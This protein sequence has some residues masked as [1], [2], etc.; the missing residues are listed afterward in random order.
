MGAGRSRAPSSKFDCKKGN[1]RESGERRGYEHNPEACDATP[2][3][4]SVTCEPTAKRRIMLEDPPLQRTQFRTRLESEFRCETSSHPLVERERIGLPARP[5]KARHQLA[6]HAF[7]ERML[8]RGY[9]EFSN[10]LW[11]GADCELGVDQR[12]ECEQPALLEPLCFRPQERLEIS[13]RTPAPKGERRTQQFRGPPAW[14][15]AAAA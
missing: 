5:I 4:N 12:L 6:E 8:P 3:T 9:L 13:E 14:P 7:A 10:Q 2:T 11:A 1:R 15:A